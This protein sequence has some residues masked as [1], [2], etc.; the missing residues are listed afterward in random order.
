MPDLYEGVML[1]DIPEAFFFLAL[2]DWFIE[3][4]AIELWSL[5][6]AVSLAIPLLPA[7]IESCA[8]PLFIEF[9]AAAPVCFEGA[10]F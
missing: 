10:L 8:T 2:L 4:L 6:I 9:D 7:V 5:A 1:P 3:L